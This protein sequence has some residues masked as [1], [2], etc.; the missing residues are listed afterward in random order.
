MMWHDNLPP[1][2]KINVLIAISLLFCRSDTVD[3]LA[4]SRVLMDNVVGDDCW[5][6]RKPPQKEKAAVGESCRRRKLLL[7]EAVVEGKKLPQEESRCRRR[8]E[9][10]KEEICMIVGGCQRP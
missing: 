1:S 10:P 9:L 7:K 2:N 6:R 5:R 3:P 8:R 4:L